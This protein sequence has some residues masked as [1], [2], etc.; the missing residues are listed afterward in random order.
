V[1]R[2][3]VGA[4]IRFGTPALYLAFEPSKACVFEMGQGFAHRF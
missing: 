3:K 1:Q 4:L 2:Q